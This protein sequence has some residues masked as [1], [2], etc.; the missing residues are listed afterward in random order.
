MAAKS[1]ELSEWG[2]SRRALTDRPLAVRLT[3][4]AASIRLAVAA[5]ALSIAVA[6]T[7]NAAARNSAT[8]APIGA[9]SCT[10]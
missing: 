1:T 5:A 10:M 9:I 4:A 2:A 8:S 3:V 6:A 7:S